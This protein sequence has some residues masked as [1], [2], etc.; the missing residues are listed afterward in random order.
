MIVMKFGGTS[1]GNADRIRNLS[2]I[3]S[4]NI[5]RKP[6]V[7]VSAFNGVTD[8]LINLAYNALKG[9]LN[10]DWL[11]NRY[12]NVMEELGLD[13]D[14]LKEEFK[15]LIGIFFLF[16]GKMVFGCNTFAPKYANS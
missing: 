10:L 1:V 8:H 5:H 3:V 7:V 11:I 4:E 15:I 9:D 14:L 6:I 16:A 2:K 12:L 13:F